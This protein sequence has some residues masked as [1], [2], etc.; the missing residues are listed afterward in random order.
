MR[1]GAAHTLGAAAIGEAIEYRWQDLLHVNQPTAQSR[2]L[3]HKVGHGLV[4]VWGSLINNC[5]CSLGPGNAKCRP[6]WVN[7]SR[8]FVY[9][10]TIAG[11]DRHKHDCGVVVSALHTIPIKVSW[12]CKHKRVA[13]DCGCVLRCAG[14]GKH[15]S[16]RG[17]FYYMVANDREKKG[18]V[19]GQRELME[20]FLSY[21]VECLAMSDLIMKK[22]GNLQRRWALGGY[23]L[24]LVPALAQYL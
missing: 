20:W 1:S 17:N 8:D 5:R 6:K 19:L 16:A 21:A 12:G 4:D 18:V 7:Q 9:G 24:C 23:N 2:F 15:W 13:L 3:Y 22:L 10:S 11:F 14:R